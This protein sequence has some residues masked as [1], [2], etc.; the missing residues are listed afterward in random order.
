MTTGIQRSAI[1]QKKVT[2]ENPNSCEIES[3]S[4]SN[5]YIKMVSETHLGDGLVSKD[6]Y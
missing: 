4:G 1:I 6:G 2:Y 3:I 5:L